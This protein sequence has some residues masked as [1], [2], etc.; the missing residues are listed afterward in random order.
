MDEMDYIDEMD[1]QAISVHVVHK[2]YFSIL[3]IM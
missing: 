3:S 2:V 1:L